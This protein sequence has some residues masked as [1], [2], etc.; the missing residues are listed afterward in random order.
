MSDAGKTLLLVGLGGIGAPAAMVL[1]RSTF[2][3]TL[4]VVDDDTVD[5]LNL[6]RQILFDQADVGRSKASVAAR[7]ARPGLAI[8]AREQR[9][10]PETLAELLDGVDAVLDGSDN[11][12]T[13]FLVADGARLR[14]VPA[15][16][17]A[18]VEW[19]GTVFCARAEGTCYRCLFEDVPRGPTPACADV[20]VMGPIVGLVGALAADAALRLLRGSAPAGELIAVAADGRIRRHVVPSRPDCALCGA[21]PQVTELVRAHYT[22]GLGGG[23]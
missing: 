5:V 4:R 1:A 13:K 15:V 6:H 10:T 3:G 21:A 8:D 23:A 14:G 2:R 18:A 11:F 17:A 19:R 22:H 12:A 9:A 20:G 7:L 16:T